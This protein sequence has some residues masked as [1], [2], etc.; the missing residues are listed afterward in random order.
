METLSQ[1]VK[2]KE[3]T[4]EGHMPSAQSRYILIMAG[5][6][7]PYR[8]PARSLLRLIYWHFLSDSLCGVMNFAVIRMKSMCA[9]KDK[10]KPATRLI[11]TTFRLSIINIKIFSV[12]DCLYSLIVLITFTLNLRTRA[13]V[14][15]SYNKGKR[16]S[17]SAKPSYRIILRHSSVTSYATILQNPVRP[18]TQDLVQEYRWVKWASTVNQVIEVYLSLTD[19]VHWRPSGLDT[20]IHCGLYEISEQRGAIFRETPDRL[21]VRTYFVS[22]HNIN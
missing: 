20:H 4:N 8:G 18:W 10:G 22:S 12:Q 3:L 5:S 1:G 15:C 21:Y 17:G 14:A 7:S 2:F 9:H 13:R 11:Q 6:F 16:G 19:P